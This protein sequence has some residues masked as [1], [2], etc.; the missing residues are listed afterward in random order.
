MSIDLISPNFAFQLNACRL[1][2]INE[3]HKLNVKNTHQVISTTRMHDNNK[4]PYNIVKKDFAN[5]VRASFHD[6]T[7]NLTDRPEDH[8]DF[9]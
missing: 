8:I 4:R 7:A 2:P 1:L 5:K 6:I 3:K 9:H